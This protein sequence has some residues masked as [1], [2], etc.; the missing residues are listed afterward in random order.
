MKPFFNLG[1]ALVAWNEL[2]RVAR[3]G[4][5]DPQTARP[6][7][8]Q[9]RH[10]RQFVYAD[11]AGLLKPYHGLLLDPLWLLD[12]RRDGR[13]QLVAT[14]LGHSLNL[15]LQTLLRAW[16]P[17]IPQTAEPA[18]GVARL[19]LVVRGPSADA[20]PTPGR[21]IDGQSPLVRGIAPYLEQVASVAQLED[22]LDGHL[23]GGVVNLQTPAPHPA[24]ARGETWQ[25]L[26]GCDW[27]QL[28]QFKTADR[29]AG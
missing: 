23:L 15:R 22:S 25:D 16:M 28:L 5:N 8:C 18:P 13:W 12:T 20:A 6:G 26:L 11:S 4:E 19:R 3:R 21:P 10:S 1:C 27:Q 17:D 14:A 2:C 9:G 29:A 7:F 24:G